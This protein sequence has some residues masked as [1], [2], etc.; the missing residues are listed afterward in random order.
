MAYSILKHTK[1]NRLAN[2]ISKVV[3]QNTKDAD[4]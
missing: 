4:S 3:G 1:I 2:T